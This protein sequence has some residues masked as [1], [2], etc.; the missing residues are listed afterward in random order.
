MFKD[1]VFL[2]ILIVGIFSLGVVIG[3]EID[4]YRHSDEI[5][6]GVLIGFC[7]LLIAVLAFFHT[8]LHSY[9]SI[10]FNK[11][12]VRPLLTFWTHSDYENMKFIL[13][14]RNNGAG[15]AIIKKFRYLVDD[16]PVEGK[17]TEVVVNLLKILFPDYH[18]AY[19]PAY[20]GDAYVMK[21]NEEVQLL[22][23][24]FNH[25]KKPTKEHFDE[26]TDK[27]GFHIEYESFFGEKLVFNSNEI[28]REYGLL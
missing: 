1:K 28:K 25:E 20:V 12:T 10:K 9:Q 8:I 2:S 22:I 27:V 5:S 18:Y 11:A 7:S 19:T 21:V 26:V 23:L 4:I 14:F 3:I 6:W 13:Y 15:S 16:V 24:E 17:G